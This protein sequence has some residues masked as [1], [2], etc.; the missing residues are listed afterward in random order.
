MNRRNSNLELLRIMAMFLIA[1]HHLGVHSGLECYTGNSTINGLWLLLLQQGGKIGVDIFILIMGYFQIMSEKLNIKRIAG[2]WLV[3]SFYSLIPSFFQLTVDNT[4]LNLRSILLIVANT[5]FPIGRNIWWFMTTYFLVLLLSPYLNKLLRSLKK[6]EYRKMITV[7]LIL[8]CVIPSVFPLSYNFSDLG[9]FVLLYSIAG[10][11][12]LFPP[13]TKHTNSYLKFAVI[14]YFLNFLFL[15]ILYIG[16]I[17]IPFLHIRI[18][19]GLLSRYYQENIILPFLVALM[20]FL[21]FSQRKDYFN[22]RIN[23]IAGAMAGVYLI[24]DNGIVRPFIWQHIV[25][26]SAWFNSPWFIV[27]T[28]LAAIFVFAA[29]TGIELLRQVLLGPLF[30]KASDV[31]KDFAEHILHSSYLSKLFESL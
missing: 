14:F 18:E 5:L 27:Y 22:S 8:W 4:L 1:V 2:L 11:V 19:N 29:C 28:A 26:A 24:H 21:Y 30:S 9:W 13:K 16:G 12:R 10:Y 15:S 23:K 20:A 6:T 31:I 7:F 25:C 3:M 17:Y